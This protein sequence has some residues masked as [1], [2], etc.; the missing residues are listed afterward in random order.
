MK[1]L[2]Y[3]FKTGAGHTGTL[4]MRVCKTRSGEQHLR[5]VT[6]N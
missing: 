5:L 1:L 2:N 4:L 6:A 3:D